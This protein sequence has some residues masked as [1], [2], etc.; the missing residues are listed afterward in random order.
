MAAL[1]RAIEAD[2]TTLRVD[3]IVNAAN[4]PL[5]GGG[6]VDGAIHRAAGPQLLAECRTLGGCATGDAKL[7][8]GYL[9]PAR[10]IIHTVGP[11]W[12]GGT[13]GE[14]KL[15]ASCYRRSLEIAA[16]HGILSIAFPSISTGVYGY[17]K[18]PAAHIAVDTVR[19]FVSRNASLQEVIFCCYSAQDPALYQTLLG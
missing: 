9:L 5:L 6:G 11:V 13:Q 18:E 1:I 16:A 7:T 3:A 15:L 19:D 14:A 10:Y 2:I 12:H 8:Q 4:N 17:P